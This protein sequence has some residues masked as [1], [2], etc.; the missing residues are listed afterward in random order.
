[1]RIL[2]EVEPTSKEIYARYLYY[3]DDYTGKKNMESWEAIE[4]TAD[5]FNRDKEYIRKVIQKRGK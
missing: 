4:R 1:M 2:K 3:M 5:W